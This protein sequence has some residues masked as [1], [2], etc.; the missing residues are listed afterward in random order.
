MTENPG[1]FREAS[2]ILASR[3]IRA[4]QLRRPKL[5]IQDQ[6]LENIAKYAL[7]AALDQYPGPILVEDS[8]L[9]IEPLNGFPG[10]YS[11]HTLKTIG[12][13][14][15]LRLLGKRSQR[16]AYFLSAV[17]YGTLHIRPRI[18]TGT[19]RGTISR[20]IQGTNGFGF[21][22]IFIPT[23]STQTFG[24]A[25][26]SFKNTHSHR[27]KSFLKFANWYRRNDSGR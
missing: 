20:R 23:R 3:G 21:D 15:I 24:Q 11:S 4:R 10:P 17:A 12:L 26:S 25:D 8:G 27:A 19:V 9:F 13:D 1:K 14:G 6:K 5:E 18:F 7:K 22:P 16:H 2:S